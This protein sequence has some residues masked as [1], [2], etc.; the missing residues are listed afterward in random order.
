MPQDNNSFS[1]QNLKDIKI[2]ATELYND[3]IGGIMKKISKVRLSGYIA[4]VYKNFANI[5]TRKQSSA[6]C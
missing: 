2:G 5:T 1:T 4:N 6:L 3:P